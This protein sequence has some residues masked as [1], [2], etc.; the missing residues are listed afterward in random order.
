[1]VCFGSLKQKL[2]DYASP[3]S[4]GWDISNDTSDRY[5]VYNVT[6]TVTRKLFTDAT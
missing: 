2:P 3:G 1:M 5:P 6:S 4:S